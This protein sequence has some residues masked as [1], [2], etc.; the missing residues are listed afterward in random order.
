MERKDPE[1]APMSARSI[2]LLL[3][4]AGF[5][6]VST[7]ALLE[8]GYLG[9]LAPLLPKF[10]ALSFVLLFGGVG[11]ALFLSR[12]MATPSQRLAN[13]MARNRNPAARAASTTSWATGWTSASRRG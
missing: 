10:I 13:R 12:S 11:V 9:I 8:V 2:I 6:G 4:I 7:L 3:V 5:G 1:E